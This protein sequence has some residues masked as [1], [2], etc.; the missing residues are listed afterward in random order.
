MVD[1][2]FEDRMFRSLSRTILA[3]GDDI[4][5]RP[6]ERELY[7]G[8]D[9]VLQTPRLSMSPDIDPGYDSN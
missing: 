7:Q 5:C 3:K 1:E 6:S 8:S 9:S 4:Q 2:R